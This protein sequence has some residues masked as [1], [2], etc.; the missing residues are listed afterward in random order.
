MAQF[1]EQGMVIDAG[2]SLH[3]YR[4]GFREPAGFANIDLAAI[5]TDLRGQGRHHHERPGVVGLRV[6]EDEDGPLFGSKVLACRN[7]R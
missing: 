2:E 5:T 4:R 7:K 1:A 6:R 3:V